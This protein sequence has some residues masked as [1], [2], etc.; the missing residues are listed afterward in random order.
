MDT[1]L[2]KKIWLAGLGALSRAEQEGDHWLEQLMRDGEGYEQARQKELD[3]LL[4]AM[5]GSLQKHQ[6]HVRQ[7]F[8]DIETAFEDKVTQALNRMGMVSKSQLHT[9]EK[10]LAEL[11]AQLEREDK[12]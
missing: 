1:N 5:T 9:L 4:I 7:R 6:H 11:E 8:D 10:R 3:N 12:G 2:P